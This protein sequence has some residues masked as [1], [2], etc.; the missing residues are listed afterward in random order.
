MPERTGFRLEVGHF[1]GDLDSLGLRSDLQRHIHSN[2]AFDLDHDRLAHKLLKAG[3]FPL[4]LVAAGQ[5]V[6]EGKVARR[7]R[8]YV[9]LFCF[10]HIRQCDAGIANCS[11]AGV[12]DGTGNG[13]VHVLAQRGPR[14]EHQNQKSG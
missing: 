5:E 3:L 6:H 12:R 14:R 13:S 7:V 10:I 11:A 2:A 9:V 4:Q 1:A 8:L